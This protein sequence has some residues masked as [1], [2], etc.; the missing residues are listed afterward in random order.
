M[1]VCGCLGESGMFGV[2]SVC[3]FF[4]GWEFVCR[5]SE[6]FGF[7]KGFECVLGFMFSCVRDI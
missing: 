2:W 5:I 7:G 6:F 4:F 3:V 1:R